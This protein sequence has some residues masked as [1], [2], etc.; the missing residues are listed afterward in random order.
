MERPEVSL[1]IPGRSF[2]SICRQ[3]GSNRRPLDYETNATTNCAIAAAPSPRVAGGSPF[4]FSRRQPVGGRQRSDVWPVSP[5]QWGLRTQPMA[6][7]NEERLL[8]CLDKMQVLS[9]MGSSATPD[10]PAAHAAPLPL[11]HVLL[12]AS[13]IASCPG[14]TTRYPAQRVREPLLRRACWHRQGSLCSGCHRERAY[15]F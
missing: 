15:S 7:S 6:S 13:R 9:L 14:S 3:S 5:R 1:T 12:L 11:L 2:R 10:A 8:K 4:S